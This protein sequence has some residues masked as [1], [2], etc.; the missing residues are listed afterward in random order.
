MKKIAVGVLGA[1]VLL[2]MGTAATLNAGTVQTGEVAQS[3]VQQSTAPS[4]DRSYFRRNN[5]CNYAGTFH[6]YYDCTGG[7]RNYVD[8]DQDGVCDNYEAGGYRQRRNQNTQDTQSTQSASSAS[9]GYGRH[10]GETEGHHG[11]GDG[12]RGGCRR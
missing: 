5:T 12:H 6:N 2:T 1:A 9:Y 8:E 10:H 11:N 7:C 4:A 3:T